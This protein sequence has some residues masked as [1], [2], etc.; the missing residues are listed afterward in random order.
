MPWPILPNHSENCLRCSLAEQEEE[1]FDKLDLADMNQTTQ[2][3]NWE[4]RRSLQ[5]ARYVKR[6]LWK[7]ALILLL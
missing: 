6:L 1:E 4:K 5:L 3:G 7:L 2:Y